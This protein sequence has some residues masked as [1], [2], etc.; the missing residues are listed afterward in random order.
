MKGNLLKGIS[1]LVIFVLL[2]SQAGATPPAAE[3]TAPAEET[4]ELGV[5]YRDIPEG[6]PH[7]CWTKRTASPAC[8]GWKRT[9]TPPYSR[10]GRYAHFICVC[11]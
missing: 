3:D 4:T 8:A 7:R 6:C 1:L 10:R 2:I 11:A 9:R 5:P